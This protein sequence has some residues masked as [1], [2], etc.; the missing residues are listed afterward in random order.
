MLV[1]ECRVADTRLVVTPEWLARIRSHGWCPSLIFN[2]VRVSF[3][4]NVESLYKWVE[5]THSVVSG[6]VPG[7][8][9]KSS[10]CVST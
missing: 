9:L 7:R 1:A 8:M 5:V 2:D 10:D 6:A 4:R 3:W